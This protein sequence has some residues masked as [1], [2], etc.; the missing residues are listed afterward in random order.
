MRTEL[1]VGFQEDTKKRNADHD[2]GNEK[3]GDTIK[4]VCAFFHHDRPV[5]KK[6]GDIRHGLILMVLRED[7]P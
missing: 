4:T 7:V 5:F 1:A 2:V 3:R 6:S